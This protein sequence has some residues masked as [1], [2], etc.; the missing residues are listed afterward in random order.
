MREPPEVEDGWACF[1]GSGAGALTGEK[2]CPG[3]PLS[4]FFF[5][6]KPCLALFA[7]GASPPVLKSLVERV[8]RCF[9]TGEEEPPV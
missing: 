8:H 7:G 1:F 3:W 2:R 6:G 4:S 9:L 5:V